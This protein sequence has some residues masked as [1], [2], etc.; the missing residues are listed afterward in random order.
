MIAL[1][2]DDNALN[3]TVLASMLTSAEVVVDE[4]ESGEAGL[5]LVD[6][7]DYDFILVDLRMPGMDG[8]EVVRAVR[9]RD[10][11]KAG[12]AIA[13]VTADQSIDLAA[14]CRTAGADAVI[15]KPVD[16]TVL[17]DV[18]GRIMVDR[19]RASG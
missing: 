13:I 10:D 6:G 9:S 3:R 14:V 15:P 11:A 1:C 4:A 2:I 5:R 16:M 8:L 7:R 17:F 12:V 18:V 19:G